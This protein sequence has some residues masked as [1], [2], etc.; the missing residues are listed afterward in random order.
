MKP[1]SSKEPVIHIKD[2]KQHSLDL[3]IGSLP[4]GK[5]EWFVVAKVSELGQ[6]LEIT[7][8]SKKF[9]VGN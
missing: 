2:V 1:Q 5:Y 3:S 6:E 7:S 4:P 8:K 9:A